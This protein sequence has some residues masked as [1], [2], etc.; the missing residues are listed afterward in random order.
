MKI[1]LAEDARFARHLL[2]GALAGWG[3]EVI[4]A[5]DG[6]QAWQALQGSEAPSIALLDWVMPGLDGLEVC[7]RVR[8][9]GR[10]PY[11]YIILLTGRDR[12]Q[13]VVE[14]LAAGADDYLRKPFD[15][16]ELEARI[17]TGRRIVELQ[18]ELI[19]AREALRE[20]ATTDPLTGL[21]NRRTILETLGKELERSRRSAAACSMIFLDF[22]HFK[23]INDTYGH[24]GGDSVLRQAAAAMRAI[25]RPYDLLGRY[26]GE[27]FVA[28]LPGCDAAGARAA[29]ERLRERIAATAIPVGKTSLR[30]TCSLGVAV[31]DARTGWER[32]GVLSAADAALYRAKRAGRD[33]VVVAGADEP[34]APGP[35]A[36]A[37]PPRPTSAPRRPAS[38]RRPAR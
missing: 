31:A 17:R 4:L 2:Q 14:G 33:R 23:Q 34:A 28:V 25:L 7:R 9:A 15:N 11:V 29:A 3:Y 20:Q 18:V 19:A 10:E 32:D 21:A 6:E 35:A 38:R 36:D 1:L 24:A 27:E 8:Q 5:E 16:L 12:P 22:D 30:V 37:E 26:G 13:D